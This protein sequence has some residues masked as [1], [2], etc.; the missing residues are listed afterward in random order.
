MQDE[1]LL[2]FGANAK[3]ADI[4]SVLICGDKVA[5]GSHV[6]ASSVWINDLK[7]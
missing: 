4:L 5:A 6:Y 7:R 3:G 1:L 2:V